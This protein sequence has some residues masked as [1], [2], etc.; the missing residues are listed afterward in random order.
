MLLSPP[1]IC[2]WSATL[3]FTHISPGAIPALVRDKR[4]EALREFL[5]LIALNGIVREIL[6]EVTETY[7]AFKAGAHFTGIVLETFER[8]H[9]AVV[10]GLAAAHHAG[11]G[12]AD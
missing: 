8:N 12:V 9:L 4:L 3:F 10:D 5:E 11:A 6:V 7:A 1:S 2:K